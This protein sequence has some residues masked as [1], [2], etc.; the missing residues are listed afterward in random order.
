MT[1]YDFMMRSYLNEDTI[2]GDLASDMKRDE[3]F[4]KK[5]CSKGMIKI[6]LEG[7]GCCS[8]CIEAFNESWRCYIEKNIKQMLY[9]FISECPRTFVEIED[10]FERKEFDYKGELTLRPKG[11][12]NCIAWMGWN[13]KAISL[14]S[15]LL[16]EY[17]DTYA[18]YGSEGILMTYILDGKTIN[19][20]V[21]YNVKNYKKAHWLPQLICVQKENNQHKRRDN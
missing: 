6:Y 8:E 4:P 15:E 21:T 3:E 13:S 18:K 2:I 19:L 7:R 10:F 14:I 16:T 9:E 1:Y 5:C 11:I 17:D 12:E 20:P